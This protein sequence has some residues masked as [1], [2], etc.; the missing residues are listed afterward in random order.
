MG[1]RKPL[2]ENNKVLALNRYAS[3]RKRLVK[4][5]ELKAKY[6]SGIQD[7][8]G[9]GYAEEIPPEELHRD[10]E[11]VH[12]LPHHPV[13]NRNKE[14]IRIVFDCSISLNQ[15]VLRGPD[16]T[17]PLTAV[18]LRFREH[19]IA[20][21]GDIEAMYHQ[22]MI[23]KRERDMLHFLWPKDGDLNSELTEYRMKVHVFGGIWSGSAANYCIKR[24]ARDN[25]NSSNQEVAESL[26]N[27]FY[28]DDWLKSIED[29]EKAAKFTHDVTEMLKKAGFRLTK[30]ISNNRE[31]MKSISPE[32]RG[33]L[34]LD[35][36]LENQE[37]PRDRA[38]GIKWNLETDTFFYE[39]KE[40]NKPMTRRGVISVISSIFD[41]LGFA[42]P[43]IITGKM[44]FQEMTKMKLSWDE[45]M[46]EVIE[47]RWKDW[48][49]DLRTLNKFTIPRCLQPNDR[50]AVVSAQLHHFCDASSQA[51]GAVTF[52]KMINQK[53]SV[54]VM[55][56]TSKARLAPIKSMSIPRLELTAAVLAAKID[57]VLR[58]E[59][60]IPLE[61]SSLWTDSEIVLS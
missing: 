26:R 19:K 36:D 27:D 61:Q 53:G 41:T 28:V 34:M 16:L 59:I 52:L 54:H 35:I 2:A 46:P 43:F 37:L 15:H 22:C 32:E 60:T 56:V 40:F 47:K 38:L 13:I 33:K 24:A 8:I 48:L 5:P 14:K 7:M 17:N 49:D 3:L 25:E 30:F 9:K 10:D 57:H 6:A 58:K 55:L 1:V 18:L 20:L 45:V 29:E 44:I 39:P 4:D 42:S 12:Y 50:V 31:V 11:Q 51:Y 23:P 21:V